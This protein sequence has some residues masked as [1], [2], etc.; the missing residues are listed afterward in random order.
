[1]TFGVQAAFPAFL[2]SCRRALELY[3]FHRAPGR[4]KVFQMAPK[5]DQ[6]SWLAVRAFEEEKIHSLVRAVCRL[7]EARILP[8][9]PFM[10]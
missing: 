4:E 10:N 1:M 6:S 3:S 2:D 9:I 5:E 8:R 7:W